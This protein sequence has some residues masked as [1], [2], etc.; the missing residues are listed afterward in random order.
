[1]C[2]FNQVVDLIQN[3]SKMKVTNS[4]KRQYLDHLAQ[5]RLATSVKEEIEAFLKG[6]N[7]I[8]PDNFL[9]MFDENELEVQSRSNF[10]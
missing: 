1:M 10:F 8:I 4:S 6:L 5:Y 2:I 3:G 9:C 7:D